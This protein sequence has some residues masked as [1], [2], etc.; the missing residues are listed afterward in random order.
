MSCRS[1]DEIFVTNKWSFK[2]LHVK[3]PVSDGDI[4]SLNLRSAFFGSTEHPQR[5]L[6][7][8]AK[9]SDLEFFVNPM[10]MP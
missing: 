1:L 10:Y 8:D 6:M 9:Y 4:L 2:F 7:L 3:L 5:C